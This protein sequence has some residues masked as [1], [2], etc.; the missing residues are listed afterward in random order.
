MEPT[1][2]LLNL[3]VHC[4]SHKYEVIAITNNCY[5]INRDGLLFLGVVRSSHDGGIDLQRD[6]EDYEVKQP[7]RR[8]RTFMHSKTSYD[9]IAG[10]SKLLEKIIKSAS[11]Q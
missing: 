9:K 2:N 7:T 8:F 5:Y 6:G 11:E 10:N 1:N 4:G 3:T